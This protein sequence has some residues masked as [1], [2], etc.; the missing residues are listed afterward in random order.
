MRCKYPICYELSP[1]IMRP[2]QHWV[3]L[4][5]E[6]RG[7]EELSVVDARLN[8]LDAYG[9]EV[10]GVPT[11]LASLAPGEEHDTAF[12]VRAMSSGRVYATLDGDKEGALFHWESLPVLLIVGERSTEL[13]SL[14]AMAEPYPPLGERLKVEATIRGVTSS[15]KLDLDFWVNSPGG[16]FQHVGSVQTKDLDPGEEARYEAEFTPSARGL[17]TIYAYLYDGARRLGRA[18]EKVHVTGHGKE[19]SA[20]RHLTGRASE[21]GPTQE[22]IKRNTKGGPEDGREVSISIRTETAG[23]CGGNPLADRRSGEHGLRAS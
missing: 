12:R 20:A 11:Y 6:N 23:Y 19:Q 21:L 1:R 3:V 18:E 13:V 15:R 16:D 9:L 10:Q 7:S 17:H 5:L 8:S 4:S 2:G 14:F 22:S